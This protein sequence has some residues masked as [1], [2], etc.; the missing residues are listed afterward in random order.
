MW[1]RRKSC[2]SS[3]LRRSQ[4]VTSSSPLLWLHAAQ[5]GTKFSKGVSSL[6][7]RWRGRSH[8]AAAG[9]QRRST[10]IRPKRS[11]EPSTD[12]G[13]DCAPPRQSAADGAWLPA[14]AEPEKPPSRYRTAPHPHGRQV[15]WRHRLVPQTS[16]ERRPPHRERTLYRN[17]QLRAVVE[18]HRYRHDDARTLTGLT[19]EIAHLRTA[20]E[21]I[22]DLARR[23]DERIRRL[24][25]RNRHAG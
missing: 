6:P 15:A 5:T 19:A 13:P 14:G 16:G 8:V 4:L 12:R 7:A 18:V 23:Q 24:E 21:A 9:R 22:A 3:R 17:Q 11:A 10:H 25:R 1:R 2:S 20:V